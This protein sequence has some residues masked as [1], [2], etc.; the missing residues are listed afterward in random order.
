M[1]DER[2]FDTQVTEQEYDE[3]QDKYITIPPGTCGIPAEGDSIY[4]TVEAGVADWK[5]PGKSLTIPLT[6]VQ[7]G[8]N[9]GKTV[10]WYAGIDKNSMSITKKGLRT[11]GIED[12]VLRRIDGKLKIAPMGFAGA[13]AKALFRRELS[14]RGNLRSV[15]DSASFLPLDAVSQTKDLGI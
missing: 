3:M 11:F 9:K 13:R 2:L 6:V 12:K 14:N 10:E 1:G 5:Q 8:I 15:L 7:E 4:L